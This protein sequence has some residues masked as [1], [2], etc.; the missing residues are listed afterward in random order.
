[1]KTRVLQLIGKLVFPI[2]IIAVT[3]CSV[4]GGDTDQH[5]V[6]DI[7]PGWLTPTPEQQLDAESLDDQK[8]LGR[9]FLPAMT[10][11]KSEP[12]F[13]VQQ[14]DSNIGERS[15]GTSIFLRPG[16]YVVKYGSGTYNQ[17]MSSEVLIEKEDTVILDPAWSGLTV[18]IIDESRNDLTT[19][20]EIFRM[21][22]GESFG[23]G[24]GAREEE[25]ERLQ[26]WILPPGLYKLVRMG[27]NYSTYTNFAS[28][29]LLPGYLTRYTIVQDSETENF[30]GS[31]IL[32]REMTTRRIRSWQIFGAFNGSF[33]L[34]KEDIDEEESQTNMT[35]STQ[36]DARI[37]YDRTPHYFLSNSILEL[38]W[39]KQTG[40]TF[41]SYLDRLEV[42]NTYIYYFFQRL[43]IYGSL[44]VNTKAL[45]E[46]YYDLPDS[47]DT[48][49]MD[50]GVEIERESGIEDIT[51]SPILSPLTFKEGLGVSLL[52]L[53][54]SRFNLNLRTGFGLQQTINREV[55][56]LE[57]K[58]DSTYIFERLANSYIYGTQATMVGYFRVFGRIVITT[59][60]D[61]IFPFNKEDPVMKFW[62]NVLNFRLSKN[63]YLDYRIRMSNE[64]TGGEYT[65][66]DQNVLVRYSYIFY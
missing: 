48:I 65:L 24:S 45:P 55:Y 43:G 33:V 13:M 61:V 30:L 28:V 51:V 1:M 42:K 27:E 54:S 31:G 2:F 46:Y 38:G 26:T 25:G 53:K 56:S 44:R 14:D 32:S 64:E 15:M 52:V 59:D 5:D 39:N 34:T 62:D 40:L 7:D 3:S 23:V 41:R 12:Y 4:R 18:S 63:L 36:L 19:N 57:T 20:Y 58:T 16:K 50:G 60:L 66:T 21:P 6:S 47:V 8:G 37:K 17:R 10:D 22:A 11:S 49:K 29:L 9:L 35:F